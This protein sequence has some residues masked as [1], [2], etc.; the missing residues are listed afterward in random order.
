MALA[1][2]K[3]RLPQ[4]LFGRADMKM[5]W[6]M[7]RRT[8]AFGVVSALHQSAVYIGKLLVQGAVNAQGTDTINA[9]T[10]ATRI[11]GFDGH[12]QRLYRRHPH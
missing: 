5:D 12:H 3:W 6:G 11:E 7:L 1:Y 4:L 2:L 9:F 10:A 8:A